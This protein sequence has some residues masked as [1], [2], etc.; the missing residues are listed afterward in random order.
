MCQ[1]F[2]YTVWVE[3]KPFTAGANGNRP[4]FDLTTM[5]L[6]FTKIYKMGAAEKLKY[7]VD[8]YLKM[9]LE[10]DTRYEFYDGELF[11]VTD[12]S[13]PHNQALANTQFELTS[14][15]RKDGRSCQALTST[16]KVHVKKNSLYC[17]PDIVIVC[18]NIET[19][20][21]HNDIITNPVVLIEVLSPSTRDYDTGGKFR[22]YRDIPTLQEYICISSEE[23]LIEKFDRK[24]DFWAIKTY[25]DI[26]DSF[27]I[28]SLNI[29]L[30]L[31]EIYRQVDFS[32][33]DIN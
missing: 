17:Y 2:F 1:L 11:E 6:N 29:I 10:N 13:I 30:N 26:T 33:V 20:E 32:L 27:P 18:N 24:E 5:F 21:G 12:S 25:K 28:H 3:E 16:Q 23:I 8:E 9:E 22:L 19:L 7:S 15:F 4:R 31:S 14:K